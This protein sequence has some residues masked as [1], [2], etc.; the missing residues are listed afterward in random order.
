MAPLEKEDRQQVQNL[1][2]QASL[3]KKSVEEQK[4]EIA[5]DKQLSD[6]STKA[7]A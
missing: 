6:D 4:I 7:A 5:D 3:D 1:I 2:N